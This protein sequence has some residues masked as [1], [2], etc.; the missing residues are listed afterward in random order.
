M[1][2]KSISLTIFICI[3]AFIISILFAETKVTYENG[4]SENMLF[5]EAIQLIIKR[6]E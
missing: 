2:D 1:E 5:I 3:I 4:I 6:E